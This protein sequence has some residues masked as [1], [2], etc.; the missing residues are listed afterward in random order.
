MLPQWSRSTERALSEGCG[1]CVR[2]E[3]LPPSESARTYAG[4]LISW[5][6]F[7]SGRGWRLEK[8]KD[9]RSGREWLV[10]AGNKHI[11][12]C[13]K[14]IPGSAKS[15]C[16][17]GMRTA[18]P[19]LFSLKPIPLRWPSFLGFWQEEEVPSYF[20]PFWLYSC[21]LCTFL[22]PPTQAASSMECHLES[23]L[24]WESWCLTALRGQL[25]LARLGPPA[26]ALGAL[27]SL[28]VLKAEMAVCRVLATLLLVRMYVWVLHKCMGFLLQW[29][30][31]PCS[32]L[33]R[34]L[35]I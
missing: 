35:R 10:K 27:A 13:P 5:K 20:F 24:E 1:S 33:R 32:D 17:R 28:W 4:A 21:H 30:H 22:C 11:L 16:D 23:W 25:G 9:K 6:T 8:E 3:S 34:K 26:P 19:V 12:M 7:W 14:L 31:Q 15:K 29:G 2:N 18:K